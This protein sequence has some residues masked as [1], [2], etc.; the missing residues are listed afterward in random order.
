MTE[1]TNGVTKA[2]DRLGFHH[3]GLACTDLDAEERVFAALGYVREGPDF[4]DPAQGVRGRFLVGAGPRLELLS[5]LPTGT[6]LGPWLRKGVKMYHVA[7]EAADLAAADIAVTGLGA[8]RVVAPVPAVAFGGRCIAFYMMP[9]GFLLELIEAPAVPAWSSAADLLAT[10]ARRAIEE[11]R[12]LLSALAVLDPDACFRSI[13]AGALTGLSREAVTSI[14]ATAL[15]QIRPDMTAEE[16]DTAAV[17]LNAHADAVP[18]DELAQAIATL[19]SER[20]QMCLATVL[21]TQL[22]RQPTHPG[23]LRA[24][25]A[26]AI[27]AGETDRAHT[28]L[29]RLGLAD[30]T[31]ATA[32]FVSTTRGRLPASAGLQTRVALLSSY[33]VAQLTPFVDLMCRSLGL[34]PEIY[35][36]PFNSWARE[37]VDERAGLRGFSPHVTFLS[38][39][40]D[41]LIPGL[42]GSLTPKELTAAGEEAL[43]R[44]VAAVQQFRTW[45]REPLVVH[46]FHSAFQDPAGVRAGREHLSRSQWLGELNAQLAERLR[47]LPSCFML[48]MADLLSRVDSGAD[49]AKMRHLAAIRLPAGVL[50]E[51][52]RAYARYIAPRMGLTRKCVVVDLDNT[53]W[54][55]IIGEDGPHGIRLGHSAPG[56]EYVEFQQ[57]L[58]TLPQRGIILAVNSK[59]N[60]DDAIQVIQ[61]HEAMVL[62]DDAF[63]ALRINWLPKPENMVSIAEELGIGVESFV[64]VDDNPK[65]RQLMRHAL[66]QILT[67]EMPRDPALYRAT[68][69]ALPELQTLE[70]TGE[71]RS[72]V[73]QYR[74][75][76]E[77]EQMR[78]NMASLEEYLHSLGVRVAIAPCSEANLS[79]VAQLFQRTNQFNVTTR[80]H[81]APLLAQRMTDPGWRL[82]TLRA[83][84]RFSDH[85]LVAIAIARLDVSAWTI[86]SFLM[87]CRV[88]SYGIETALLAVIAEDALAHGATRLCGEFVPTKKNQPACDLYERHGFVMRETIDG[89]QQW[90]RS[91]APVSISFP[92]WI[93]RDPNV[94]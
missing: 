53:L 37:M 86:E 14:L 54:G 5:E 56:S 73:G 2:F 35:V 21:H 46:G 43:G 11:P 36:A 19:P 27:G 29:T 50:P 67:V 3:V 89:V 20:V 94:A 72:R 15:S 38:V 55:G 69:E 90:E 31:P 8:K 77:R 48:D 26:L 62:R 6:V 58:A 4:E 41:D 30:P 1:T 18:P 93:T 13:A 51:V 34:V 12:R 17:A 61:H 7:Y 10:A 40:V 88:I 85:G 74:A 83:G 76:R 68:L 47:A 49:A 63:S 44:V 66:P 9:N 57:F 84:D 81:D 22:E 39:A 91:L 24:A 28:L 71:D 80:R 45:S 64:F 16:L 78:M 65:E 87:S 60:F 82:Y 79:R 33:T 92:A 32:A 42:V 23:L 75:K 52:A 25:A 70:V 59:N